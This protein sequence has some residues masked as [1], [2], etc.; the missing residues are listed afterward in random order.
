MEKEEL[1]QERIQVISMSISAGMFFGYWMSSAF[2]GLF[3]FSILVTLAMIKI[4]K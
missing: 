1:K 2:A 3:M 4:L